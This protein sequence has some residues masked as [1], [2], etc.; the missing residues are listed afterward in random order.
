M[1]EEI[2][3]RLDFPNTLIQ[4]QTV[5]HLVA[6]VLKENASSN[7]ISQATNQTPA[8]NLLWEKCCSDN[9]VVRTA[10]CEA[11]LMLVAQDHAEFSYVIS[12]ALNLI[13]SARNVHGLIKILVKLLQSQALKVT[14]GEDQLGKLY[15]IRN[16]PHPLITVLENRP[17]CWPVILQQMTAFLQQ[18]PESAENSCVSLMRPFLRYLYC[19]PCQLREHAELRMALLRVLLQPVGPWNK[20]KPPALECHLLQ[21]F[22]DLVPHYQLKDLPQITE[23][24]LFLEELFRSLLRYPVFWRAQL[25]QLCLQ[26]L[27][28]CEVCLQVTGECS[29]LICLLEENVE[30]LK[31]GIPFEMAII[32]LGLLLLQAPASQQKPILNLAIKLLSCSETKMSPAVALILVMPALQILSSTAVQDCM[33]EED[34][35]TT[36]QQ[37]AI[38]LLEIIQQEELKERKQLA[39]GEHFFP[40]TSAYGS[41]HTTWR[42]LVLMREKSSMSDWLSSLKSVLS[43]TTQVPVHVFLLLAYLFIQENGD[44]LRDV[45]AATTEIAK[46]DSSQVPNLIPVLM[47]KLGKPLE[48]TLCR[49]ILYTLPALG[50]HKVCVAQILRAL[51]VLGSTPKL[52]AVTLRLMTSLWEKQDRVYPELQRFMAMSDMAYLSVSKDTQWE[53]VIAKAASIR[54]ICK[55]RPYQHGADMLAAISQ[56]LNECTEADQATP[57]VLVLQGL[58]ALCQ[59]EAVC[60]RS[61]WNALSPKLSCDTRPLILKTLSELFSLVPSLTVN[62]NEYEK[63]KAQVVSF[64]WSH[65]QSKDPLIATS[66]YKSLSEFSS[67][68]HTILHIPEQ[69]RPELVQQE[70]V[71]I[72]EK[73]EEVDLSVP[74][75]SYIKL[76]MLTPLPVLPAF[77]EFAAS[78]VK[79]EMTSMPRGIYHSALRGGAVRSDQGKTVSGVPSFMLKMYERNKQPGLKPGLAAGMLLSYDLPIHVG[80]DGKPISR[81]LASRGRNFHQMLITLIHE[82]NIQP[83]EWHRSLLLP[84]S[85][86]GF[87]ERTYHAILQGRQAELEMQLKHGREGPEEV[88][89]KQFTAWL[90]IRDMLTDVIKGASKESP[91]VKGNCLLALTGL[92]VAVAKHE[93]GLSSDSEE[94][95]D[96]EPDFLLTKHWISMVIDTLLSIT[97]SHYRSKGQVFPWFYQKSYSGENTAS[98]IARSCAATAL[99][100]LV[101]VFIVSYKE[102]VEEVLNLLV[103]MLPGKPNA[104]ESQAVQIHMGLALGMFIARLCE[105]KVSDVCGKQMNFLL[106]KSLD[107]LEDCCFDASLEYNTGCILGIGLVLSLMNRSSLMESQAHISD[108]LHKLC[109][110]LDDA[111]DQSR[112]FQEILAYAIACV[113][114]SAFSVKIIE[115]TEAEEIMN[116][117]QKLAESNQQTPGFALALGN[118]V[119]GLSIC[120]HGKAEDLSNRLFP[121]WMKIVLAEGAPTMQR[122]AAINGLVSVVGSEG[123]LIQLK[124]EAI[125][126]SQF[127]S[128]LNEVIR[129][130]SQ[131]ISFSGVI[132]LQTNAAWLLGHLHLSSVSTTHSQTSVPPD[133][134]YLPEKSFL[135]AAVDFV[136]EGGKKGPEKVHPRL[137][138]VA[139]APIAFNG[140]TYQYPSVNWASILSPLLRLNFGEEIQQ[141]CIKLAVTQAQSSQNAAMLLGMWVAPP[142]VYSLSMQ[143]KIYLFT[144]LPV[145][146][147]YVADD[148]LQAFTE[149]FMV[150]HFEAKNEPQ[151]LELCRSILQGLS[152]AMKLPIPSQYSWSCLSRAVE[153]I[154]ELLPNEIRQS[155]VKMY[156]DAAKCLSEMAD[157]E[158][159]RVTQ[160][161]KNNLKKV[162]FVKVYLVSQGRFPLLRWND[163]ISIAAGYQQKETIV[164]MLL[165]SFYHAR[166]VSHENTGVLKRM[167]WLLELMGYIKTISL[168]ATPIQ[169]VAPKEA[170]DFL[171]WIFAASVVAWA[172]HAAPLLLGLSANWCLWEGEAKSVLSANYLG[173]RAVDSLA[174]QETLTLFPGSLQILLAKEPWKDQTQKFIDWLLSI[175]ENSHEALSQSSRNL[176]KASLLALRSIPEFKKKAIWTKA[177]GW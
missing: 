139:M 133:F 82:V 36:R 163:V 120:G 125:Q 32:G 42:I 170:I 147:K 124:S 60:I 24:L 130:L 15:A 87:M 73:E 77:E 108:S 28:F 129:T 98:V 72:N 58:H 92:A 114:V 2:R 115:A 167:E 78:L 14:S 84:Q 67:E 12:G 111:G 174:I 169:N 79:Q 144:S 61:T 157:T 177:Y 25:C 119:H 102:K 34:G 3:K 40:I 65:A 150:Q 88:Q 171:L 168:K 35:G 90:W 76:L 146:M 140:E 41:L 85:W 51:Q 49:D 71:D 143:T 104:D 81:F 50:V 16:S 103:A 45:L 159:D 46:A 151:N 44:G 23:T 122:L 22:C 135:R 66:A 160:V 74:G 99:S 113:C 52:Q 39:S 9:V 158:I 68:E 8:L 26:L 156:I 110:Y 86:A 21:M 131:V 83:S 64:L 126:S 175:M 38:H 70:E 101:P 107:T 153:R 10:C 164:W 57:A 116:K 137:V 105:E 117:L 75:V 63:F 118:I 6:A 55:Q 155:E 53:K 106:I 94:Q 176:L 141:L 142:L 161:S 33:T 154:F 62:S 19:E 18:C 27:C 89:Y 121:T 43:I 13:P 91:V 148:R 166:I 31:E 56:V 7:K 173:K 4:S 59:A 109:K 11:L 172:D 17:D 127:Q 29:C 97:D 20:E 54:D 95:F 96:T 162:T 93:K 134:S 123:A 138:K 37:L 128:K 145:W 47:F 136:I 132:G 80:K 149:V 5:G 152:Q 100:L 69:A 48:P 1:S 30:L 112:T 165:H